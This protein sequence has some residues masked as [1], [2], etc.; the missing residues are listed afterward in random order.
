V[1]ATAAGQPISQLDRAMIA[2]HKAALTTVTNMI[3]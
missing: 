1:I 2:D 3:A